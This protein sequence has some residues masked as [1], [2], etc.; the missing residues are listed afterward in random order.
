MKATSL[1]LRRGGLWAAIVVAVGMLVG[2]AAPVAAQ[3]VDEQLAAA[4]ALFDVKKYADAAQRLEAFLTANPKHP[5]VAAAALTQA[6]CYAELKQYTK[7]IPAYE[8]A[9]AAKDP[10]VTTVAQL[11]L[12]EAA[13]YG[14][15]YEKAVTALDAAV[16]GQL[17]PAQAPIALFLL[18]QAQFQL[19]QYPAAEVTYGRI[20]QSYPRVD[21][22]DSV[23]YGGGLAAARQGKA[24]I[25][26]QRLRVVVDRYPKSLDRPQAMLVLGQL[27]LEAKRYAEARM[28]LEAVIRE[29]SAPPETKVSAETGLITALLELEEYTAATS[30]LEAVIGRLAANDPQ[31]A[32]AH[33]SLGHCRYRQKQYEPALTAYIE[34]AKATEGEVAGEAH[35]WAGNSALALNRNTDASTQFGKVISRF[36]KHALA[37]RAQLKSGDALLAAKQADAAATAYRVVI[38]KYPQA[39]EANDAKK[40]LAGLFDGVTDPVQL[41]AALKNAAPPERARGTLRLARIFLSGKKYADAE[42]P[43]NELIKT[44]PEVAVAAEAQYLLGLAH[45]AQSRPAPAAAALGEA[46]RQ[47][48]KAEWA[49]DAQGRLAWLYLD[50]KQA[51]NAEKAATAALTGKLTPE[52]ERQ[53]RLALIQA[54]IDQEKWDVALEGCRA[55]LATN[56]PAETVATVLYTQAWMSE[57]REKPEEA[58]PLWERLVAEHPK[59]DYVP[60]ALLHIADGRFRAE[61]Y[62]EARDKYSALLTMFPQS[63]SSVEARYKLGSTLYNLDKLPEAVA[64]WDRVSADKMAGDYIAEALYWAGTALE[65]IGKKEDALLRMTRVVTQFPKHQ[66]AAAA[67]VRVAALKAVLGK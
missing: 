25:A 53:A 1:W 32:R 2:P 51:P 55:L 43:L 54:Q 16:K 11:G 21:F 56:P 27:D 20:I 9:I 64:E 47:A 48:P 36:P 66:R 30:R 40:A 5:K 34:A 62:A 61:Q 65:K 23:Y 33:L 12:G 6:R 35:Y 19:E 15:Q 59:S 38:D 26:R 42:A 57:K 10:A 49:G 18:A 13:L 17:S 44:K 22:V 31:R 3:S 4:S 52:A 7:A 37:A 14:E 45:E 67:K 41:A 39:P 29:P 63:G 58:L 60:E 8:K 28:Q 46:I 50:L 24:D